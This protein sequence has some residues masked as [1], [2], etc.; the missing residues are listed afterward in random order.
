MTRTRPHH[1][2]GPLGAPTALVA[3]LGHALPKDSF[4]GAP[5]RS[6]LRRG[7]RRGALGEDEPRAHTIDRGGPRTGAAPAQDLRMQQ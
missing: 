2:A 4:S 7:G 6:N 5:A 1:P 3:T